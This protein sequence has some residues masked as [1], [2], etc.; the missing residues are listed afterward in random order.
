MGRPRK[1]SAEPGARERVID[2]FWELLEK[3]PYESI[4]VAALIRKAKVSPT[5]LY[6]HFD[7]YHAVVQA[8]LDE[9]LDPGLLPHLVSGGIFS[10]ADDAPTTAV[11][12]SRIVLFASDESGK[13]PSLLKDAL[14][15]T[16]LET[17]GAAKGDLGLLEEMELDFI[18]AGVVSVLAKQSLAHL[19]DSDMLMQGFFESP[20][21]KGVLATVESLRK[22]QE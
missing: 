10:D 17:L 9:T 16:W 7:S 8:A 18:F 21:G 6:Y 2:A 11:R 3:Q 19:P 22:R 13:L 15:R 4:T 12:L 1:D 20:L 5:T 14:L